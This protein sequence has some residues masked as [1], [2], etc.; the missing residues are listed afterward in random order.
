MTPKLPPLLTN[1]RPLISLISLRNLISLI[2]LRPLRH[3]ILLIPLTILLTLLT[4]CT[5]APPPPSTLAPTLPTP[6]EITDTTGH[7]VQLPEPPQRIVIAGKAIF[8]LQDTVYLF[9][10]A[11]QRVV[12]LENRKQ[13]AYNF[14]PVIDENIPEIAVLEANAGPEQI[15][16]LNPDLVLMKSYM[17]ENYREPLQKL[18]IPSLYLDLETPQAFYA[19][20]EVLGQVFGNPERAQEII[21][22]YQTRVE[23]VETSLA[24]VEESQKPTVLLLEYSAQGEEIAFS[25]PPV[26]WLQTSLVEMAGGKPIWTDT[27]LG[28]GWTVANLEQIAAWNPDKIFIIDY[29]GN[30]SQ[31]VETLMADPLWAELTAVREDQLYAFAFDFYSWDQPDTRWVLGLQWLTT[32]LHPDLTQGTD[33]IAESEE[34]Y[35]TL[36]RLDSST[37]AAEVRPLFVGDIP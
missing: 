30:A 12:G 17:A 32:K 18:G 1:L 24:E 22:F 37:I 11:H 23:E 16:A 3:L 14:L 2:S 9:E 33:I 27:E 35:A 7:T 20:L 36:Y 13:S 10:E 29:A 31:V 8:M 25:V 4:A 26:S 6:L 19:D 5:P 28:R 34:F 15:A 21:D